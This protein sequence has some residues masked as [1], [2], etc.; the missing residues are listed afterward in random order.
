MNVDETE[1]PEV[2][3]FNQLVKLDSETL[4]EILQDNFNFEPGNMDKTEIARFILKLLQ[5]SPQA[6]VWQFIINFN[7]RYGNTKKRRVEEEHKPLNLADEEK[8]IPFNPD[9]ATVTLGDLRNVDSFGKLARLILEAERRKERDTLSRLF[10]ILLKGSERRRYK[11]TENQTFPVN[12]TF[13]DID[14]ASMIYIPEARSSW[15]SLLA[16]EKNALLKQNVI[17]LDYLIKQNRVKE[18]EPQ[19]KALA[20]LSLQDNTDRV[21]KKL[22]EMP[23]RLLRRYFLPQFHYNVLLH[24][25]RNFQ[26]PPKMMQ[27]SLDYILNE[28]Q[29]RGNELLILR[30]PPNNL[31]YFRALMRS[32]GYR[33]LG[34]ILKKTDSLGVLKD[35]LDAKKNLISEEDPPI[36]RIIQDAEE[37]TLDN[38][39]RSDRYL[40]ESKEE[41]M[42]AEQIKKLRAQNKK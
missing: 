24:A 32:K 2:K 5:A 16:D 11:M 33:R 17:N 29:R 20:S 38:L 22:S 9:E 41:K 12:E 28:L 8:L 42:I 7:E 37:W 21:P 25:M 27:L 34:Q 18:I 3:L 31:D 14:T 19:L 6:D 15:S 26:I 10:D 1:T 39:E 4:V 35:W 30:G 40:T 13:P 36:E 23:E